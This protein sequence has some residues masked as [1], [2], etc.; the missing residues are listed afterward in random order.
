MGKGDGFQVWEILGLQPLLHSGLRAQ[1]RG[2]WLKE[3]SSRKWPHFRFQCCL[4]L[5]LSG[6]GED[7]KQNKTKTKELTAVSWLERKNCIWKEQ[8]VLKSYWKEERVRKP[9]SRFPLAAG[10]WSA[11]ISQKNFQRQND[12]LRLIREKP[13]PTLSERLPDKPA[14]GEPHQKNSSSAPPCNF[15]W[16]LEYWNAGQQPVSLP[17][18]FPCLETR[19]VPPPSPLMREVHRMLEEVAVCMGPKAKFRERERGASG[20]SWFEGVFSHLTFCLNNQYSLL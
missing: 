17:S 16:F 14:E 18:H 4:Y 2:S 19:G 12:H 5:L 11:Q 10:G 9:D 6:S 8:M 7:L 13:P 1:G 3:E 15:K 20:F